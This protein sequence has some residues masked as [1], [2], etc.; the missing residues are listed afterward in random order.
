MAVSV[1]EP[2]AVNEVGGPVIPGR[3]TVEQHYIGIGSAVLIG[4]DR[5]PA[6]LILLSH[7]CVQV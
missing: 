2:R 1:T 4:C 3:Q 7:V 6:E 5:L